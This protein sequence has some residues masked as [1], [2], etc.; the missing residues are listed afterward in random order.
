VF[1][2][3]DDKDVDGIVRALADC[4]DA[5]HLIGLERDSPRGLPAHALLERIRSGIAAES[6]V[7]AGSDVAQA[8][9]AAA[10]S[11]MPGDRVV[12]FGSFMVAA[13]ALAFAAARVP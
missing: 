13:P 12:A 11:S 9:A 7:L 2:A 8:I 6:I 5:W 3:L 4:V 10:A 1:G